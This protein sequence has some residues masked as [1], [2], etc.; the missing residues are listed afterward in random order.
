MTA[1]QIFEDSNHIPRVF[2]SPSWWTPV[3]AI[4]SH[5]TNI[6]DFCSLSSESAP[7][8]FDGQ[9]GAWCAW[10]D[11]TRP[12]SFHSWPGL[13]SRQQCSKRERLWNQKAWL[14]NPALPF[15][16]WVAMEHGLVSLILC[17]YICELKTV[18]PALGICCESLVVWSVYSCLVP[19]KG[20]ELIFKNIFCA[21][22]NIF[23]PPSTVAFYFQSLISQNLVPSP[24]S[25]AEIFFMLF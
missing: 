24:E 10:L 25:I 2:S 12:G 5:R 11:K 3:S 8:L 16:Y 6:V 15:Q 22:G 20:S 7:C 9:K 4:I 17:F 19:R 23:L 21:L 14:Q 18:I 1:L 13:G